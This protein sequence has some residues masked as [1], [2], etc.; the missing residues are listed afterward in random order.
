MTAIP[1]DAFDANPVL[2][3]LGAPERARLRAQARLVA[4]EAREVVLTDGDPPRH[5]YALTKGSVRVFHSSP[6]GLEVVVKI[7]RA[8]AIFG[9]ME[10]LSGLPMLESVSTLEAAEI[11]VIPAA[12]FVELLQRSHALA[13]GMLRDV[14]ARL[15]IASHNEKSLAFNSV[16]ARL[17]HFL[18][19][20]AEFDGERTAT[21]VRIRLRMTQDDMADA[22]GVTRRAI[23]KEVIRWQEEG[24]LEQDR[25]HYVI[26]DVAALTADAAPLQLG[27]TYALGQTLAPL[28]EE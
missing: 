15:C 3:A 19:C 16:R 13:L 21:G 27:L 9:E 18:A 24:V 4:Y 28:S 8:P 2:R 10:A 12:T 1:D 7:F 20:Y 26:R 6:T 11:V 17:A 23:A 14:C 22:L 5:V 25:G